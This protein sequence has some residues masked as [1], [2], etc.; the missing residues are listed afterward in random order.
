[1]YITLHNFPFHSVFRSVP[2]SV[3]SSVP[4]FSITEKKWHHLLVTTICKILTPF[5]YT[6]FFLTFEVIWFH[7]EETS[8]ISD[9]HIEI[10]PSGFRIE[11]GFLPQCHSSKVSKI[12]FFLLSD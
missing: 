3:P 2:F 6:I 9:V 11:W 4:R 5:T 10:A 12:I 7:G 8:L 1:M